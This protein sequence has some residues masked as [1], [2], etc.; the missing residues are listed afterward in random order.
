ML[1]FRDIA[2]LILVDEVSVISD[3]SPIFTGHHTPR[4][5]ESSVFRFLLTEIDDSSV[6]AQEDHKIA[7][8][9]SEGKAEVI[10]D[11]LG[12]AR[13]QIPNYKVDDE[14]GLRQQLARL[15][16]SLEEVSQALVAEQQSVTALEDVRRKPA[17]ASRG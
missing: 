13:A 2:K 4:T 17:V 14:P 3:R 9:R 5:V 1:S 10:E 8:G 7:K 11:L 16:A 12:K 6:I 15:D